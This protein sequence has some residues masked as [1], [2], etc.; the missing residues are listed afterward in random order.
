MLANAY[1]GHEASRSYWLWFFLALLLAAFV[2]YAQ[3]HS[4]RVQL[5]R[6]LQ[7]TAHDVSRDIVYKT[8]GGSIIAAARLMGQ[9]APG[10]RELVTGEAAGPSLRD[11]SIRVLHEFG[12]TS[13]VIADAS[14]QVRFIADSGQHATPALKSLADR[15]YWKTAMAGQPNV[16]AGATGINSSRRTLYFSAPIHVV[17][18]LTGK[19]SIKGVYVITMGPD[20]MDRM[21]GATPAKVMLLSPDGMVYAASNPDWVMKRA[22]PLAPAH[23]A[24][25]LH[26]RQFSDLPDPQHALPVPDFSVNGNDA[27]IAGESHALVS[28]PLRWGSMPEPWTVV[29]MQE[30]TD[31]VPLWKQLLAVAGTMLVVLLL[32]RNLWLRRRARLVRGEAERTLR[33]VFDTAPE[34]ILVLRTDGSVAFS[35]RAAAAMFGLDAAEI[36]RRDLNLLLPG[37]D[38]VIRNDAGHEKSI[39]EM[40]CCRSDGLVVSIEILLKRFSQQGALYNLLMLRDISQRKAH[41]EDIERMHEQVRIAHENLREMSYSL[42]LVMFQFQ[43]WSGGSTYNFVSN[44]ALEIMGVSADDIIKD[45]NARWRNV[46]DAER[47]A[48]KEKIDRAVALSTAVDFE[49]SVVIDGKIRWIHSYSLPTEKKDVIWVWNGFWVD[50]TDEKQ[51]SLELILERERAEEAVRAKSVFLANMSHEIRTPMNAII[52]LSY[53]ALK[54]DLDARQKD[55]VQKIHDS[56]DAL[57]G[58]I[59]DILDFSKIEAGKMSLEEADF[60][61]DQV[62]RNVALVTSDRAHEKDLEYLFSVPPEVPRNLRGD[63][64]RIGQVLINLLNNAIK[65]TASGKVTLAVQAVSRG[66]GQV[67]LVFSVSDSGIGM[68]PEQMNTLFQPFTQADD[69]TTRRFGGTGLGLSI[70]HH[71]V[72]MMGGRIW[73]DSQEGEGSQFFFECTFPLAKEPVGKKRSLD[74]VVPGMR[75]LIVDDRQAEREMLVEMLAGLRVLPEVASSAVEALRLLEREGPA[76]DLL[77]VDWQMPEMDGLELIRQIRH[78]PHRDIHILMMTAFNNSDIRQQAEALAVRGFLVKPVTMSDIVDALASLY[79]GSSVALSARHEVLPRFHNGRILLAEDNLI[80]QQIAR[81]LLEATGLQVDVVGNGRELIE[82]LAAHADDHY[83]MVI[84]DLQM[85]VMD[86]HEATRLIREQERYRHL[87]IIALTAHAMFEERARCL[88]EGMNSHI[89]KP[90]DPV[91]LY[92]LLSQWLRKKQDHSTLV[93]KTMHD[94]PLTLQ[95]EGFD[96]PLVLSRLNGNHELLFRLLRDFCRDQAEVPAAI[97]RALRNN[98]SAGALMLA[99][100]LKG[101]TANLGAIELPALIRKLEEAIAGHTPDTGSL[102]Q[103]LEQLMDMTVQDLVRQRPLLCRQVEAASTLTDEQWRDVLARLSVH[104]RDSDPEAIELFEDNILRLEDDFGVEVTLALRR[105]FDVFDFDAAQRILME[106]AALAALVKKESRIA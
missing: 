41:Q 12:A 89:G 28:L 99:H 4:A 20:F 31:L 84:T 73:A 3:W 53:L 27:R 32:G 58:I 60:D 96:L 11:N 77:L 33:E 80:N 100:S 54:T 75:V 74:D 30:T 67:R 98:D 86:G 64:L 47:A 34:G 10:P 44:K 14:G 92:R 24:A 25:Q 22:R 40:Q 79:A 63:A 38:D 16:Y 9:V 23:R 106:Q 7:A 43:M 83:D 103:Q 49:H 78:S 37:I 91:A 19:S 48:C 94:A 87:P 29:V 18:A 62:L 35:N 39:H 8:S 57:L 85:P 68:S 105:C 97:G 82:Q 93:A 61:F 102:L 88:A 81:E 17:D 59:N 65:F 6:Q 71:L 101:V 45:G 104:V 56:G 36:G 1:R 52:G 95:L 5:D 69:S 90:I 15:W 51:R 66:E 50:V 26:E 42:P 21:L 55:Y 72:E 2:L 46:P 13:V 70:C 76:F